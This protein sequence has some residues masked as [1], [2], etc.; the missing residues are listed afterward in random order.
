MVQHPVWVRFVG[1]VEEVGQ[2][3]IFCVWCIREGS[4]EGTVARGTWGYPGGYVVDTCR[5]AGINRG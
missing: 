2:V 1:G 5:D 3:I 4:R